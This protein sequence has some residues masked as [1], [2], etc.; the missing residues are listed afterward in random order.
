MTSYPQI[1]A[2]QHT[3]THA[4]TQGAIRPEVRDENTVVIKKARH[5]VLVLRGVNPVANAVQLTGDQPALVISGPNAGGKT[6]VLKTVGLCALL[7]QHACFVPC[8]EGAR[9]DL[10]SNI[11]ASIG[12]A[13]TV[14]EDL[15]S[16]SSHMKTLNTMVVHGQDRALI[17]LDE[18]CSG[19][20]PAQGSAL[21]QVSL[22]MPL[23][24]CLYASSPSMLWPPALPSQLS[25]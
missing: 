16:F 22:P 25:V 13:Q 20:D 23:R 12:D 10:F 18:I 24:V 9:V 17:L 15:S 11:L 14:E 3:H 21:A 4:R 1:C 5:P 19:T 7:V 6:V 2:R 8:E